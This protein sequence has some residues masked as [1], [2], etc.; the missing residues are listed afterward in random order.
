[1]AAPSPASVRR[2]GLGDVLALGTVLLWGASFTVIKTAYTEF[3]PLA[4]AAVRFVIASATLLGILAAMRRP[5]AIARADLA[6]VA[7]VGACHI[8]LYQIFFSVGLQHTTASNSVL[9]INTAP[10]MT[11]ALVWLTR[12]ERVT[13]RQVTG[14]M[15]AAAGAATLVQASGHIS[16]GHLTGDLITL[17]AA[18]SYAATPVIVLPLYRRYDTLTVMAGAM[19]AGSVMLLV[20]GAPELLRQSWRV[21]PAAWLQLLYAAVGAGALGYVFWYE[22]IRRIGPTRTSAYSYLISPVGV[23]FAV[24]VLR[25]PFGALHALGAVVILAGVALARWPAARAPDEVTLRTG[26]S[27]TSS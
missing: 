8:G 10:V 23:L 14:V 19:L 20:A 1:V 17:L 2:F 18:A 12:S 26:E 5:L 25:E 27:R 6:R 16:T 9:L 4:F 15:L 11:M 13:L 22:G 21:S 24:A 3:T 7:A